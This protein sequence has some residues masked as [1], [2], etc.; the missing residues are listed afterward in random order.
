MVDNDSQVGAQLAMDWCVS[1][2]AWIS[3][4]QCKGIKSK[5]DQR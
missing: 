3:S 4:P 5:S 1:E 2:S